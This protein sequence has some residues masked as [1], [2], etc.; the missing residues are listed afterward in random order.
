MNFT[1]VCIC[2]H[3][4]IE[5]HL[6]VLLSPQVLLN[7]EVGQGFRNRDGLIGQECEHSMLNGE[8]INEQDPECKCKSYW[9]QA[10]PDKEKSNG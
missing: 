9:D 3:D 6:S 4:W 10:W 1:G 5:H 8:R 2:G 7:V